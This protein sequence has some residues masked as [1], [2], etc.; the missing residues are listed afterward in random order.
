MW[1]CGLSAEPARSGPI[2]VPALSLGVAPLQLM[3]I[4][5]PF[6]QVALTVKTEQV[7]LYAYADP[8]AEPLSSS[9][10]APA[11]AVLPLIATEH[12]NWS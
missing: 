4:G 2:P 5:P 10:Q 6:G 11:M 9:N 12:P 8:E 7:N 3:L 1:P